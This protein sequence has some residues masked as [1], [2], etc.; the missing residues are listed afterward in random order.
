MTLIDAFFFFSEFG[1]FIDLLMKIC[2]FYEQIM[3]C[4]FQLK[5]CVVPKIMYLIGDCT[6]CCWEKC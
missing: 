3:S 1:L 5:K 4:M 2:W 6:I